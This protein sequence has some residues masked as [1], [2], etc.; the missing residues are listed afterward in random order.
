M[1]GRLRAW[2][3]AAKVA[4]VRR[5]L[6]APPL[7]GLQTGTVRF[8][9]GAVSL[10]AT[11]RSVDPAR[12]DVAVDRAGILATI[13]RHDTVRMERM[14]TGSDAEVDVGYVVSEYR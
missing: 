1:I 6:A 3:H 9:R 7:A 8:H 2:W 14:I 4:A 13:E 11:I 5:R 10:I 12:A